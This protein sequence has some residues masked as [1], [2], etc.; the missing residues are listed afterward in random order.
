[1]SYQEIKNE[2]EILSAD[3]QKLREMCLSL[4]RIDVPGNFDFRLKARIAAAKK[5]DFQPRFGFAFRYA[6]PA[7][8]LIFAFVFFAYNSGFFASENKTVVA[9]NSPAKI[10]ESPQTTLVPD[11]S[12]PVS[13]DKTINNSATANTNSAIAKVIENPPKKSVEMIFPTQKKKI[14]EKERDSFRGSK[15]FLLTPVVP[16]QPNFNVN[17]MPPKSLN[18][19]QNNVIAVENM[20]SIS[21]INADFENGKW[22]VKSVTPNSLADDSGV[23]QN[24]IIEAVDD[25][26]L[27]EKT[28]K[29]D[30]FKVKELTIT[31]DGERK[32]IKLQNK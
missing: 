11:S 14:F 21:G 8:A 25:V 29:G 27:S 13:D 5:S 20:L 28:I 9:E 10:N 7:F 16:Q 3:E 18:D 32:I 23:K 15:D 30:S 1:M 22:K 19:G 6:L 26:R 4:K 17:I 2:P 24:D 12:A 31:R